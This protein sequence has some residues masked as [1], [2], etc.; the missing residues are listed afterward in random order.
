MV[1]GTSIGNFSS[2][3]RISALT[4]EL[5]RSRRGRNGWPPVVLRLK[6]CAVTAGSMFMLHLHPGTCEMSFVSC[7][8]FFPTGTSVDAC[9]PSVVAHSVHGDIVDHSF[10]VDVNVSYRDVIHGAVVKECSPTP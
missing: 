1:V 5:P 6:K 4:V 7:S 3:D 2:S 8:L 10:V 9:G